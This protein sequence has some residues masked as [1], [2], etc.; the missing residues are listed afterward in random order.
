[1]NYALYIFAL[2]EA[3]VNDVPAP[4]PDVVQI[5]LSDQMTFRKSNRAYQLGQIIGTGAVTALA[6][7]VF[8][9]VKSTRL[10]ATREIRRLVEAF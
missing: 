2:L 8:K 6:F 5:S 9:A 4:H 3:Y 10:P 1:M 7:V